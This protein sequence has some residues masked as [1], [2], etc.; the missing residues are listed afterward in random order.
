M[1]LMDANGNRH[2]INA[3]IAIVDDFPESFFGGDAAASIVS[4]YEYTGTWGAGYGADGASPGEDRLELVG[5]TGG[6]SSERIAV[7][8]GVESPISIN[9]TYYGSIVFN[10]GTGRYVFT[11]APNVTA[12]LGFIL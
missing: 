8:P 7:T 9:G 4:G 1:S 12:D 10:A 11:A 2:S 6:Q 3:E 5:S